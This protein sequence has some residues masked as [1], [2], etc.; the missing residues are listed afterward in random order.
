MSVTL[1]VTHRRSSLPGGIPCDV[2]LPRLLVSS[3]HSSLGIRLSLQA[4]DQLAQFHFGF[5]RLKAAFHRGLHASLIFRSRH[6]FKEE[7][8]VPL[9][10]LG[11]SERDRIDSVFDH[12]MSG[13][14]KTGY[15]KRERSH[16]IAEFTCRQGSVDPAV[17]F[18]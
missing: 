17:A 13:R 15:T 11:G 12:R 1:P 3:F 6:T 8:G 18:S 5:S 2:E 10:L 9:N 7:I 4:R 16:E 14:G